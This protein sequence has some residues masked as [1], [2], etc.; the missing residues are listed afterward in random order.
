VN[1]IT[2]S[3]FFKLWVAGRQWLPATAQDACR[4]AILALFYALARREVPEFG[5]RILRNSQHPPMA[6]M[7]FKGKA[8]CE[9][10][11][12]DAPR[13]GENPAPRADLYIFPTRDDALALT[14]EGKRYTNDLAVLSCRR[15]E[16]RVVYE[17]KRV[18]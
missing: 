8:G 12:I 9:R 5:W 16:L 15:G 7:T 13:R 17:K 4:M 10:W 1:V 11:V 14:P 2:D 18:D 6:E 3:S